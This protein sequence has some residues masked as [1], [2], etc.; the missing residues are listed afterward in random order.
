LRLYLLAPL[1]LWNFEVCAL[2]A[3]KGVC[4]GSIESILPVVVMNCPKSDQIKRTKSNVGGVR[5]EEWWKAQNLLT[6]ELPVN[7][8]WTP[9][10]NLNP[11]A[12]AGGVAGGS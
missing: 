7:L 8:S 4:S 12:I 1:T 10:P 2:T 3:A 9:S 11:G 6:I 5:R